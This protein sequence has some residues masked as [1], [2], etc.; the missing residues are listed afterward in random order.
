[1]QE[2]RGGARVGWE[3]AEHGGC[4][5]NAVSEQMA[6]HGG[7]CH[8][9]VS[10]QMAE[11]RTTLPPLFSARPGHVVCY[12]CIAVSVSAKVQFPVPVQAVPCPVGQL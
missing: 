5:H 8:N 1:M 12:V 2:E 11:L 3:G 10:E 7:C 6:E 4:C 9:A